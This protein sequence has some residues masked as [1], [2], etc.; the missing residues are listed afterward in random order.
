MLQ[1]LAYLFTPI[2]NHLA[3]RKLTIVTAR[4]PKSSVAG[5]RNSNA[6]NTTYAGD[7]Q[8]LFAQIKITEFHCQSI[9]KKKSKTG[10]NLSTVKIVIVPK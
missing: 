7:K 6:Q 1:W 10:S 8:S 9:E 5:R 4:P 3:Y 2:T